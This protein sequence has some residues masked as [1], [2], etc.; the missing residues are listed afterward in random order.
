MTAGFVYFHHTR[1]PCLSGLFY[2]HRRTP[3]REGKEK[4]KKKITYERMYLL[5]SDAVFYVGRANTTPCESVL[6]F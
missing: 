2:L 5:I 1:K 4:K 6:L 3:P